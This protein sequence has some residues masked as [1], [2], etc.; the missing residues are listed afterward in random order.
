MS[1]V[2]RR[3]FIVAARRTALGRLGGLHSRRRLEDLASP[4]IAEVMADARLSPAKVDR[5]ILGNASADSNPARL[6]ALAAGL[7]EATPAI[8][9]DQQCAS[10]LE[11]IL[12][13]GR[14]I[15]L[16][17][18]DVVVAGGA[19]AISMAPWRVAKPRQVHLAPRFVDIA[20]DQSAGETE[21][22]GGVELSEALA[23]TMKISRRQQ[24]EYVLRT[25][26]RASLARDAKRFLKEIVPLRT[27]PEEMRDQSAV[28]PALDEIA[29]LPPLAQKGTLT[30]A[31]ISH[32]HDGA[33]FVAIVSEAVWIELGKPPALELTGSSAVGASP[34]EAATV[35]IAAMRRL[36][37]R[38]GNFDFKSLDLV[39]LSERS[40]IEAIALRDTLGL[41][42]DALNPDGGAIARGH[43]LGAASAVL[44]TRVFSR[45]VRQRTDKSP[46]R[47]AVVTSALGG[48]AVAALFTAA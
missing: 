29:G 41:A 40:A 38:I 21:G 35:T 47:G 48:Q 22:F 10:G 33:A 1:L 37:A 25:H 34:K 46:T 19:E 42:E 24:D 26:M 43:P 28:E 11:A 8:T 45:M 27:T 4:V 16:G 17:E 20:G 44:V 36:G 5:L 18:A 14:L 31:A 15:A 12:T 30:S 23:R 3:Q 2:P 13:A 9:V 39:E 32:L 6:L 7:P